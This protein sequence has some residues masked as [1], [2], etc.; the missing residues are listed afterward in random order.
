MLARRR[1]KYFRSNFESEY[2]GAA[3][4]DVAIVGT[5]YVRAN[6]RFD[7]SYKSFR[8]EDPYRSS[9]MLDSNPIQSLLH[10]PFDDV[11]TKT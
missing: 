8:E 5:R 6:M 10:L 9:S 11:L 1:E 3:R 7:H 2:L 4:V